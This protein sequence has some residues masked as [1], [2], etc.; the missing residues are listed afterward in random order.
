MK[1]VYPT[2]LS[3]FS[4]L[5]LPGGVL[6]STGMRNACLFMKY[7]QIYSEQFELTLDCEQKDWFQKYDPL[8]C[9]PLGRLS[10]FT[11]EMYDKHDFGNLELKIDYVFKNKSLLVQAF[12][13]VS[14]TQFNDMPSYEELEFLGDDVIDYLVAKYFYDDEA[15]FTP[16]QLT[17]LKQ[18]CTNNPFFGTLS[19]K[20]ELDLYLIYN[21]PALFDSFGGYKSY[22][23]ATYSS[24]DQLIIPNSYLILNEPESINFDDGIE[25]N[26]VLGNLA[27]FW[28]LS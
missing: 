25:I 18:S 11:Y 19:V 3:L 1:P 17:N 5:V 4:L 21:S 9:D 20:Y 28:F 26:K 12:K 23:Q 13:H 15:N 7:L 2:N 16:G 6:T 27:S 22:F 10:A 14:Y 8:S 24:D